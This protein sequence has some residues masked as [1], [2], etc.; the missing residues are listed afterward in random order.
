MPAATATYP[1]LGLLYLTVVVTW[2]S[3]SASSWLLTTRAAR[4]VFSLAFGA[5]PSR[6]GLRLGAQDEFRAALSALRRDLSG[7]ANFLNVRLSL[8]PRVG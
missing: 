1:S 6:P 8:S 2:C 7:G 5:R 3:H 4:L